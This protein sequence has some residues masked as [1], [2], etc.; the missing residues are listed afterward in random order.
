MP[1]VSLEPR[2]NLRN[3]FSVFIPQTSRKR[4]L[5]LFSL[6]N[7]ALKPACLPQP[8]K[9]TKKEKVN[10]LL[11]LHTQ[12]CNCNLSFPLISFPHCFFYLFE[13]FL[14]IFFLFIWN[15]LLL[16]SAI[17]I[18][19]YCFSLPFVDIRPNLSKDVKVPKDFT[20]CQSTCI[21]WSSQNRKP[22]C[23]DGS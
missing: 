2:P 9:K 3:L 16:I 13:H 15:V 6:S 4:L 23:L 20:H 1:A 10:F 21:N 8:L 19:L 22:M 12:L 18:N 7:S 11:H 5:E 17:Q 14:L